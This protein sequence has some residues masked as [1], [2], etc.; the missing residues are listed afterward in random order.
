MLKLLYL[1]SVLPPSA[2]ISSGF[3]FSAMVIAFL[4]AFQQKV[5]CFQFGF[6]CIVWSVQLVRF[7]LF[8][9]ILRTEASLFLLQLLQTQT[10]Y[11]LHARSIKL[12]ASLNKTNLH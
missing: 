11:Y 10:Y 9:G 7:I 6:V 4:T 1:I 12:R 8:Y 3:Y 2:T 5:A